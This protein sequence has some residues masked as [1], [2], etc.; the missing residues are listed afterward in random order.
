MEEVKRRVVS[1]R[2]PDAP[3]VSKS[4]AQD[5]LYALNMKFLSMR[6]PAHIRLI[7]LGYNQRGNM[8]GLTSTQTTAEILISKFRKEI[9]QTALKFD[10]HVKELFANQQW[11]GLKF[12]G[13][14]LGR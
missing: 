10:P 3:A 5:I 9:L 7:K 13:V 8:T 4:I 1:L 12:H 11:I 6:L 2:S 14:E